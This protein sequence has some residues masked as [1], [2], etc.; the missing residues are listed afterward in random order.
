[1]ILVIG[2]LVECFIYDRSLKSIL[3]WRIIDIFKSIVV[4]KGDYL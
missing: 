2:C 4:K 1:M 3:G